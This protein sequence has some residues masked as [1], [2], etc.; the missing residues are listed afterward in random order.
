MTIEQFER[1]GYIRRKISELATLK[2]D[3]QRLKARE[4]D[5]DFNELR[6]ISHSLISDKIKSLEAEFKELGSEKK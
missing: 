5:K 1:A 6:E 4:D 3:I 2:A